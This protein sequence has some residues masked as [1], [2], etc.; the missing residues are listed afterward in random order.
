MSAAPDRQRTHYFPASGDVV[1]T[2]QLSATEFVAVMVDEAD[3]RRGYG[4]T[5][6]EAIADLAEQTRLLELPLTKNRLLQLT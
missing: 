1:M 3:T 4:Q 6:L 2:D 5:R